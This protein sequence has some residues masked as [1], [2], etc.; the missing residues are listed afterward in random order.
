MN[1]R[2]VMSRVQ[3]MVDAWHQSGSLYQKP[4]VISRHESHYKPWFR[5]CIAA[6]RRQYV[7]LRSEEL[8]RLT[9]VAFWKGVD[10]QGN[11]KM[12]IT[13]DTHE[14]VMDILHG[15]GVFDMYDQKLQF[16]ANARRMPG[17][18]TVIAFNETDPSN[19]LA[20]AAHELKDDPDLKLDAAAAM[21]IADVDDSGGPSTSF[22]RY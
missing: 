5:D 13:Y 4:R 1:F 17:G 7:A 2:N 12:D 22:G 21:R 15:T 3:Y 6:V 11:V 20:A 9:F 16:D 10:E 8:D 14:K 19:R 18:V